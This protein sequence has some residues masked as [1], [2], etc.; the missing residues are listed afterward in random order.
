MGKC[1]SVVVIVVSFNGLQW[2]ERCLGSL[3]DSYIP[4]HTIVVDNASTDGTLE[5]IHE[6]F[7]N[8]E[9]IATGA[10]L[11]FA[12]ANNVG[13]KRALE[14]N[15]DYMFLLNQDAWIE[16]D[17]ISKLLNTFDEN[18]NV[19]VV[20]PIHLNGTKTALDFGF[21]RYLP[22][23]FGSDLYM[24]SLKKYYSIAFVNAAAWLMSVSC[25]KKVGG[26]DTL[27]FTHY[28]EDDNYLQRVRFHGFNIMINTETTICHDRE[29]RKK[30]ENEYR[31]RHF[32][33]ENARLQM[34]I[35]MGNI[36]DNIDFEARMNFIKRK[37]LKNVLLFRWNRIREYR[38]EIHLIMQIQKSREI[39]QD[40]GL[41]WLER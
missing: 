17:T 1:P 8:V 25:V 24:H 31:N 30:N 13:I 7:P 4:L 39:N 19:G 21:A 20:S 41:V 5:Y 27:L 23:A 2:Y 18:E 3:R 26:F 22:V 28:G 33:R 6:H 16:K 32:A 9:L 34:K 11:G 37:I 36:N 15:A 29:F 12:K 10:N 35:E 38:N 40:G 14:C